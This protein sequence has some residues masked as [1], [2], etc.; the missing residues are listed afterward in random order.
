MVEHKIKRIVNG[1]S[2][3]IVKRDEDNYFQLESFMPYLITHEYG[4]RNSPKDLEHYQEDA[5]L[6]KYGILIDTDS[7]YVKWITNI[8]AKQLVQLLG[9]AKEFGDVNF[10]TADN[11]HKQDNENDD[12]MEKV[13]DDRGSAGSV[14]NEDG[15]MKCEVVCDDNGDMCAN[16]PGKRRN[17]DADAQVQS[18]FGKFEDGCEVQSDGSPLKKLRGSDKLQV[19]SHDV[20]NLVGEEI[21]LSRAPKPF[22]DFTG[23]ER[24]KL[25][26]FLQRILFPDNASSFQ[27][28]ES[29]MEVESRYCGVLMKWDIP[30][31]GHGNT[32]LHWLCSIASVSIIKSLVER[33][34]NRLYGDKKGETALVKSVK[35]V[36]NYDLETFEELLDY[37][38]PCLVELDS[39]NRTVLHHIV[40]TSGMQG[41]S[42]AAKYYLDVL[43][44][45][46]VKKQ[47]RT[48]VTTPGHPNS[49]FII[50]EL[51]L[52]WF[53]ANVVNAKDSNGDTCLSIAA[54]LGN[55]SIVEALL[56]Y[57]ADP[58]ITNNSGLESIDFGAG[59][60][61]L[62]FNN[63]PIRANTNNKPER[64]N[65]D[66]LKETKDLSASNS[67]V[68]LSRMKTLLSSIS[69]EYDNE[70]NE[71]EQKLREL[72]SQLNTKRNQLASSRDILARARQLKDENEILAERI[73]NIETSTKEEEAEFVRKTQEMKIDPT[74]Y[75][76]LTEF[77]ADEPFRIDIFYSELEKKLNQEYQGDLNSMINN[78]NFNKIVNEII[79]SYKAKED[80]LWE[81]LPS[82]VLLKARIRAYK[83]NEEQLE[84]V[85]QTIEK[86]RKTLENKFRRV[87]SLC[88]KI[89]EDKIDGMLDGLLQAIT[90][91]DPEDIDIDEM[92]NFLKKHG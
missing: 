80:D 75:E 20:S 90:N 40:L 88:L 19:Y 66:T 64:D 63:T 31:D 79:T 23:V 14:S 72:Y 83:R 10:Q 74:D 89:E 1:T 50:N 56:D 85:L 2:I 39:L 61:L 47:S 32:A 9:W 13:Q 58:Y 33:G 78:I 46:I 77:D 4:H 35:S 15:G 7:N 87:L 73:S 84:E 65:S 5:L 34:A 67:D 49:D 59:V 21:Q 57:G 16:G 51:G 71:H 69:N 81:S 44:G 55:I 30:I 42:A 24:S 48:L 45:W 22:E 53:V 60:S 54:R 37:M 27:F 91:E 70:L 36:N 82:E 68:L 62:S 38:Y 92:Q 18:E 12:S 25:E 11:N 3:T 6:A 17:V 76:G 41:C 8:K 29:L 28:E 52:K 26:F 43:M 86:R